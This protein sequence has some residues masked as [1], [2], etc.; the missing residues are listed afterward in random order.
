M[1]ALILE[2]AAFICF[3]LATVGVAAKWN[4][5]AAGLAL[6]TFAV[7]LLPHLG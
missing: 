2:I 5:V 6:L 3:V 7:Y 1:I 4:L